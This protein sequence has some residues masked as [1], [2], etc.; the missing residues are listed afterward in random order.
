MRYLFMLICYQYSLAQTP[1]I[2][3]FTDGDFTNSIE[4]RGDTSSFIINTNKQLQLMAEPSLGEQALYV[5]SNA[6]DSGQWSFYCKMDFNPSSQNYAEIVL[7]N[8]DSLFG[9]TQKLSLELGRVQDKMTIRAFNNGT[10]E[11]LLES[12]QAI[13]TQNTNSIWCTVSHIESTWTVS[14]SLDSVQWITLDSFSYPS[15]PTS[16]FGIIC[17]YTS[18]RKDKF[19]F[20]DF[21]IRGNSFQDTISPYLS[22]NYLTD[23][24][25]YILEFSE[26]IEPTS[27]ELNTN[28]YF[29]HPAQSIANIN[30]INPYTFE[31]VLDPII[32][33]TPYTLHLTGITDLKSN[34]IVDTN[35]TFHIQSLFP[36]DIEITEL[37]IDPSPPVYLPEVEYVEIKNSAVYPISLYQCLLQ[38]GEKYHI[39]PHDTI[40]PNEAF[41]LYPH[42][43]KYIIDSTSTTHIL[44]TSFSLPN[45]KGEVSILDS[46]YNTIHTLYYT[47]SWYNDPNKNNGGWSIEQIHDS[48]PCLQG[49]NWQASSHPNG[50]SP[51]IDQTI[52]SSISTLNNLQPSAFVSSDSTLNLSFPFSILDSNFLNTS[53]YTCDLDISSIQ[54]T[55]PFEIRIIFNTPIVEQTLYTLTISETLQPCFTIEWKDIYFARSE[56]P[57]AEDLVISEVCFNTDAEH[58]EFIECKNTSTKHLNVYDL[59]LR[60]QKD[61]TV[62]TILCSNQHLLIPSGAYLVLAKNLDQLFTYYTKQPDAIYM[63]VDDWISLDNQYGQIAVLDRSHLQ[64]H[65]ICYDDNW[66]SIFLSETENVSLEKININVDGCLSTSWA[67]AAETVNFATPGYENSQ[68]IQ[69]S[70]AQ[71]VMRSFSP[72]NDGIEDLWTHTLSFANSENI[73]D[74]F[75]YD[76]D[77]FKQYTYSNGQSIGTSHTLVWN[78]TS[79]SGH[80]L[81]IGTY[82][83]VVRNRTQQTTYKWAISITD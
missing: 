12:P 75:V 20:D 71:T 18:S 51:S 67:S 19:F 22:A 40:Y 49:M 79:D 36:Y 57:A 83:M 81:P 15:Q 38:V 45:T 61:S 3:D 68:S 53:H 41:A 42:S 5:Y 35:I 33:N 58:S 32:Y 78:G 66:H 80:I 43:A 16:T 56:L 30:T 55:S 46:N 60:V 72:N 29:D 65:T 21:K 13:L 76:L 2:D 62:S 37:M 82:I 1:I 34:S 6:I 64:I 52:S 48:Y 10:I 27:I 63:E 47:D 24:L 54:F 31:L 50:G 8:S 73:I 14:Y 69:A 59:A 7:I 70:E 25:T 44:A 74:A 11:T 26:P 9:F 39:L 17:H 23:S 28:V 77:G 4:W